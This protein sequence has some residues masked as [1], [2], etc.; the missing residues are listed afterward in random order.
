MKGL[1]Q[2]RHLSHPISP[3]P[4]LLIMQIWKWDNGDV[5]YRWKHSD[6]S[7]YRCVF[8]P[9]GDTV[10]TGDRRGNLKV[11]SL[12]TVNSLMLFLPV[13]FL[14]FFSP[15]IFLSHFFFPFPFPVSLHSFFPSSLSPSFPSSLPSFVLSISFHPAFPSLLSSLLPSVKES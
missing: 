4:S 14:V 10:A 7:V 12:Y 15:S 6:H 9:K 13:H 11:G 8:S 3:T 5:V 2:F 1:P